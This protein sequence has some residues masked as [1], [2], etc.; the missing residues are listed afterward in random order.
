MEF[1][2]FLQQSTGL[3]N[4]PTTPPKESIK[5]DFFFIK[6]KKEHTPTIA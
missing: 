6:T 3:S 1:L 4:L 2:R 5:K